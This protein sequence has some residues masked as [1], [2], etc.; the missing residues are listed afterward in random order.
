M[1]IF[2]LQGLMFLIKSLKSPTGN[3]NISNHI[4]VPLLVAQQD[5]ELIKS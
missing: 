2:E 4:I 1:F 3:F 5:L